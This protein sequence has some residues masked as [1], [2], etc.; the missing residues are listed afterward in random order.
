MSIPHL[1]VAVREQVLDQRAVGARHAGVVDAETKRQQIFQIRV[2]ARV[3]L[4]G[5]DLAGSRIVAHQ[6]AHG[7]LG[8]GLVLERPSGLG[9]FFA[10][11][12]KNEDLVLAGC[13]HHLRLD[14]THFPFVHVW[15][16][17][18]NRVRRRLALSMRLWA[19]AST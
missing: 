13:L 11:V 12:N 10:A 16:M 7:I 9:G 1:D 18:M 6:A 2:L 19:K 14:I 5:Q 8:D 4:G 15:P 3:R 17:Q